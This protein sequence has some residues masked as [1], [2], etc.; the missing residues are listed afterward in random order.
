MKQM[1]MHLPKLD[2]LAVSSNLVILVYYCANHGSPLENHYE[3]L[4][5]K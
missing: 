1:V 4:L 3:Q 2:P 5:Y